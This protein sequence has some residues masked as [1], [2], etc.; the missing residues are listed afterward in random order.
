MKK[1]LL[2]INKNK[3]YKYMESLHLCSPCICPTSIEKKIWVL[4]VVRL[5]ILELYI[6]YKYLWDGHRVTNQATWRAIGCSY[7]MPL[8]TRTWKL[9]SH[10]ASLLTWVQEIKCKLEN[11]S[12]KKEILQLPNFKSNMQKTERKNLFWFL[13]VYL[14]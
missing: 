7:P 6:V 12:K 9:I 11:H 1:N 13:S 10:S 14:N 2:Y 8:F 4:R 3:N 5:K